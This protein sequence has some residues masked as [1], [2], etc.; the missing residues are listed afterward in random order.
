M[1]QHRFV[2][3]PQIEPLTQFS[4]HLLAQ[5]VVRHPPDKVGAELDRALFRP[6]DL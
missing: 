6:D 3:A 4:F 5:P 2:I 1:I